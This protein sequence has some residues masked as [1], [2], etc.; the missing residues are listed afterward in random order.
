M[1]IR[2]LESLVAVAETG[3]FARAADKGFMTPAAVSRQMKAL[4]R[5]LGVA[6]FDRNKRSPTLTPIGHAL[7]PKA[8]EIALAYRG[9]SGRSPV[10]S[11]CTMSRPSAPCRPR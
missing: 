9:R 4:E 3:T 11:S 7:V 6:L 2:R 8:R 10:S 1:S 5:E